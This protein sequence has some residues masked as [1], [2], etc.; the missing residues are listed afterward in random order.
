MSEKRSI[1]KVG[2]YR[3]LSADSM[4]HLMEYVKFLTGQ[5]WSEYGGIKIM[6]H[7][8]ERKTYMQPMVVY[9]E[10]KLE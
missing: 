1:H 4:E 6:V 9:D 7:P 3:V 2:A 5:G 10:E 8:G